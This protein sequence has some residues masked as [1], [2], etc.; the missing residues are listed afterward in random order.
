MQW[1]NLLFWMVILAA[2]G[3]FVYIY[4]FK[5]AAKREAAK[6]AAEKLFPLKDS[7][8]ATIRIQRGSENVQMTRQGT[9]WM[10]EFPVKTRAD[11]NSLQDI[12][13][14]LAS[15]TVTRNLTTLQNLA[16]LGLQPPKVRI[17]F[18]TTEGK[19][20]SLDVGVKDFSESNVYV[21]AGSQPDVLLVP[22][23]VLSSV[24]KSL[25]DLRNRKV[26]DIDSEKVTR[27]D[28]RSKSLH[29]VAQKT[30]SNWLLVQPI[31]ANGDPIGI[32]SFLADV[33]NSLVS[34]FD[35]HPEAKL[36]EYGLES[37]AAT[38][39]VTTGE[40]NPAAQK[41]LLFGL[42]SGDRLYAKLDDA[43][44]IF[45]IDSSQAD[46]LRADP[47]KLRDKHVAGITAADLQKIIIQTGKE[48]YAFE[49][50][51]SKEAQ[52]KVMEPRKVA[53]K[54]VRE[55]KFWFPLEDLTADE[56]L[57]PPQSQSKAGLFS[58]PAVRVTIRDKA[59][60]SSEI[61]FS[62][63]ERNHVWVQTSASKSV[64]R[65]DWKKTDAWISGLK[66]SVE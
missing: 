23:S 36:K 52:W 22:A 53:G 3:G 54:N 18:K 34:K 60:R 26:M 16:E 56:I 7:E 9:E 15:A 57:D 6:E 51:K 61:R 5:G 1:R 46:K 25:Y 47:L 4:E 29:V 41:K 11:K 10:I 40:G 21:R 33:A 8:I 50:E 35:D 42:K 28:Y 45:E 58:N 64:Y 65:V 38:L 24:D 27:L 39:T 31:A 30:G 63:P 2:L 43:P 59:N 12:A 66:D 55:W 44:Q 49:R 32:P 62:H 13:A 19:T 48:N 37:P 14:N 20:Y 17:D